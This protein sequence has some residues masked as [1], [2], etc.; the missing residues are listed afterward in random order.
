[1]LQKN[2]RQVKVFLTVSAVLIYTLNRT[3]LHPDSPRDIPKETR[4]M[5]KTFRWTVPVFSLFL[6]LMGITGLALS[7]TGP[8]GKEEGKA[9]KEEKAAPPKAAPLPEQK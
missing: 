3:F 5:R 6:V 1:M 2:P 8:K 4:F 9:K 7:A